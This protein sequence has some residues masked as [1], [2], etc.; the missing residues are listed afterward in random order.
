MNFRTTVSAVF[1]TE[2]PEE[3]QSIAEG[4]NAALPADDQ[5]STLVT[6]EYVP[7]GKPEPPASEDVADE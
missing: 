6:I 5:A 2:T 4:V 3:A 7:A 1:W